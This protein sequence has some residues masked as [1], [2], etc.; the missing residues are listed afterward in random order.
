VR[1]AAGTVRQWC[2]LQ[3][4]GAQVLGSVI[5][6][7]PFIEAPILP[8]RPALKLLA[9]FNVAFARRQAGAAFSGDLDAVQTGS[10]V[11]GA[12]PFWSHR[13]GHAKLILRQPPSSKQRRWI[14]SVRRATHD[15][16][17]HPD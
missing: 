14:S 12:R 5:P 15:Q 11:F 10:A 6:Y 17:I 16:T 3:G 7:V 1:L 2:R 8:T 9:G 4:K 13:C